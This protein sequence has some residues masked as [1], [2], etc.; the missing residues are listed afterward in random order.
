MVG[1]EKS[2]IVSLVDGDVK[3]DREL[4]LEG[5]GV[6]VIENNLFQLLVNLL[7]LPQDDISFP[8]NSATIEL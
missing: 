2:I 4:T 1:L 8:F 6:E 5:N 7:L 3:C